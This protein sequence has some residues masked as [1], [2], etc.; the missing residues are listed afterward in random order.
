MFLHCVRC[1]V[2]SSPHSAVLTT[3]GEVYTWGTYKDSNGHI[4]FKMDG[5][6]V[7]FKQQLPEKME[8]VSGKNIRTITSG[9]DF[10][11]ALTADGELY[12]WGDAENSNIGA[13]I[14]KDKAAKRKRLVPQGPIQLDFTS[15]GKRKQAGPGKVRTDCAIDTPYT[16]HSMATLRQRMRSPQWWGVA[17]LWLA[18]VPCAPAQ[19][20]VNHMSSQP[21][22]IITHMFS[23]GL[24]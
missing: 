4:G 12:G 1:V 17:Y 23:M 22:T 21:P 6:D 19:C 14:P 10:T 13:P 11:L 20:A 15:G 16:V 3:S 5:K 2:V 7:V 9:S 8:E 18:H 24:D